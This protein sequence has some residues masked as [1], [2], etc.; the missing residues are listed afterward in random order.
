[1]GVHQK[2]DVLE[3]KPTADAGLYLQYQEQ[4]VRTLAFSFGLKAQDFNMVSD[5]N[6]NTSEVQ[7]Q[8]SVMEARFPIA[9]LIG[10]RI[11]NR[12]LPRI[13]ALT[14][15]P[16]I[17]K[18]QFNFDNLTPEDEKAEADIDRIY[19]DRDTVTIDQVRQRKG[20]P[21]LENGMGKYTLS[22]YKA[23]AGLMGMSTDLGTPS[24]QQKKGQPQNQPV[25]RNGRNGAGQS[26][27]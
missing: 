3:L 24:S 2:P 16:D 22:Q 9:Q 25:A 13:A 1:M 14:G 18:L 23:L 6:R 26:N 10:A 5:V 4:L 15:D 8:A 19:L 21:P 7:Q 27:N 17:L 11:T 12:V 20:W